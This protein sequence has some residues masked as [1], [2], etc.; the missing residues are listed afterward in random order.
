[1]LLLKEILRDKYVFITFELFI[2]GV[3]IFGLL[4]DLAIYIKHNRKSS[5][6]FLKLQRGRKATKRFYE[7][8]MLFINVILMEVIHL[9]RWANGYK[10]SIFLANLSVIL[11]LGLYNSWFQ[12]KLI[13]IIVKWEN[14]WTKM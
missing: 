6:C 13:G 9:M 11:Y 14:R 7:F 8:T 3:F 4:C 10:V 5:G 1:M 2:G 12:N